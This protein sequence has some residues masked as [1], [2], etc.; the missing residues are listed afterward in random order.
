MNISDILEFLRSE[1]ISFVFS[2]NE[3]DTVEGF[4]SLAHYRPGSFTWI[5]KQENIPEGFDLSRLALAF[6][7]EDVDAG[8]APNV[9]RTPES[10]RAFFSAIEHFYAQEEERPAV[11]QFT[12]IS[13]R[14]KLGKNVRIGHNCTLDGDITIGDGTVIWNNV[15]IVNRVVI[16]K[17]C[18]IHSGAVIGH[19]G[20]AYTE[21]DAHKKTMVK[22]FGGVAIGDRVLIGENVCVSR[23]TI[24]DTVLESGVKIDSLSHIAHNCFYGENSAAAAPCRTNG[25]VTVGANAYLAGAIVRNQC[26]VGESAFIGLGSVVVKDVAPGE[27]VVGNPARPLIKRKE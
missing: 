12:Y 5:K 10:K 7:S 6:V 25:S 24:D 1:E 3:S 16:G 9:I 13:P 17:D 8:N 20:Y 21:D 14:V 26:S 23:G 2:G 15:V 4:S 27:T 22:H 19:D 11:G 18:D